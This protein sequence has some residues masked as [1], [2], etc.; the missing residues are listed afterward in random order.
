ML[1]HCIKLYVK[2]CATVA[3]LLHFGKHPISWKL[4]LDGYERTPKKPRELSNALEARSVWLQALL[5]KDEW[6]M[7]TGYDWFTKDSKEYE[8]LNVLSVFMSQNSISQL[9][10]PP[11]RSENKQCID[12]K[13]W[14]FKLN[15]LTF[16][17]T[18][19]TESFEKTK[20]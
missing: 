6:R 12:L 3:Y 19:E 4:S 14:L 16:S 10:Y 17:H 8:L 13:Q 1:L 7:G 15:K 2:K 5:H 20:N 9:E 18:N 11:L